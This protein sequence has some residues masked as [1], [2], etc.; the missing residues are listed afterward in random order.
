MIRS[1]QTHQLQEDFDAFPGYLRFQSCASRAA[2]DC[3]TP[4]RLSL[5]C[6]ATSSSKARKNS[7]PSSENAP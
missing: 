6:F 7:H 5:N 2:K 3:W 1:C 4:Q